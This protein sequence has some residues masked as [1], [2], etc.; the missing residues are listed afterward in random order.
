MATAN[1]ADP[2]DPRV[3]RG[4]VVNVADPQHDRW[5]TRD[6]MREPPVYR[7]KDGTPVFEV[8]FWHD[9]LRRWFVMSNVANQQMQ[10]QGVVYFRPGHHKFALG[11]M[12][13]AAGLR[14]CSMCGE[15]QYHTPSG[16][17]CRKGHGGEPHL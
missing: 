17:T 7:L 15:D 3:R 6:V 1:L 16:W 5:V 14:L 9:R 12:A 4:L 11:T 8:W 13:Q 2:T 10:Q